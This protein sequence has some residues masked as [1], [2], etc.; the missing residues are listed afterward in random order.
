MVREILDELPEPPTHV[1]LQAGVGGF[2]A[3][4]AGHMA[5]VLGD[6]RPHVTVVEPAR[7]ACLYE[8]ARQGRPAK[9]D[10]TQPTIMAMLECQ[11][12][13]LIAFRILE[14]TADG[15]M[16]MEEDVAP[17]VMRRLASPIGGDPAIVAGESGGAGL[18]GLL[19]VLRDPNLAASIGL[20]PQAR[21]LAVNTEGATDPALY[22]KIVGRSP[23]AVL[24]GEFA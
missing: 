18:A 4:V 12:A 9:V 20:D 2:A 22:E 10:E 6:L 5:I 3:A 17:D 21:V 11:E 15:F 1:F 14:R 13:S 23:Q 16:T 19:T 24:E 8:S 7:A